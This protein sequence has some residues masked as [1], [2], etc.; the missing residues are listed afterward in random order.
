M[1]SALDVRK[2][3][4][5]RFDFNLTKRHSLELVIDRQKFEPTADYVRQ[6]DAAFIGFPGYA[7]SSAPKSE[8]VALRSS[9]TRNVVNELRYSQSGGKQLFG[10]VSVS[11]FAETGGFNLNIMSAGVTNPFL[12]Q[13]FGYEQLSEPIYELSDS[14]T[15]LGQGHT[16]N[17]GAQYKY[18]NAYDSQLSWLTPVISFAVDP[19]E[20]TAFSMFNGSNLPGSSPSQQNDARNLYATLVGRVSFYD[21]SEVLDENGQ[22]KENVPLTR[23]LAQKSYGSY[24]QDQWR[25]R[26]SLSLNFGIGWQPQEAFTV[27]TGNAGKLEDPEEIW[28]ISGP[29]NIFRPGVLSGQVPRVVLYQN[30]EK[31]YRDDLN[32]FAPS[33]GFVW[34]PGF[35]GPLAGFF[36]QS[37]RS[38]VRA[39]FSRSF[40]R[41]GS[42]QQSTPILNTPGAFLDASRSTGFGNFVIGTNLR[43]P[44]NPNLAP[45][46]FTGPAN[47][48][49][50]LNSG[51]GAAVTVDPN[52]QTGYVDSFS[53]GYQ[54]QIG[55]D[56][57]L[58][59]RYVGT[60][61]HRIRRTKNLNEINVIENGFADEFKMAQAN[62]YANLAA[63]RGASF[64][65]FGPGT[66]TSALPI[67]LAYFNSASN[68][69]PADP[70]RYAPANFTNGQ[71]V[72]LLSVNAPNPIGFVSNAAF[73]NNAV[74]RA[75]AASNGLPVN[76]F[77]VNPS[78]NR[79]NIL[80][81]DA[82]TWYD[83]GVIELR[84][85]L[86]DGLRIEASYVFSKALS[87]AFASNENQQSDY[88]LRPG[89]LDLARNVQV[90]D[91]RHAF[92]LNATYDLPAGRGKALFSDA[93]RLTNAF[94]GG[95][96]IVPVV[97]WQS[98]SPFSLGNVQ[99]AGMTAKELQNEIRVRKGPSVVTY[100]PD[101]II[102]NTQRAFNVSAVSP[103]GYGTTFGGPPQGRFIAPP[104]YG[105]CVQRFTGECGFTNLILHGPSFFMIDASV[106]KK[107]RI[108][109]KRDVEFRMTAFDVLNHPPFRV[110]GW[111][112]DVIGIG[113]GGATFGQL[114]PGSAYQDLQGTNNPGG[115][116]IDLMLRFNF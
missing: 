82:S 92:K 37:G 110:G 87:N 66:G 11:D 102:L 112:S 64:A 36:G 95:W 65:Y 115:R 22:F 68:Y 50:V 57:V 84:R 72:N 55:Q 70:A 6:L 86:S 114:G 23:T 54:R 9:L 29:G 27:K 88:T 69:D 99:L 63:G 38:V 93:R 74:R 59:V 62:L 56:T 31:A 109:E 32:N 76:F 41:E 44:N 48:P 100:L 90:F 43:D 13:N 35:K 58:E 8:S 2:F 80:S 3:L 94:V 98:G 53:V 52:I 101:D 67:M 104:G 4:T 61:G 26:Q 107:F 30:G 83:S 18:I 17:F 97:R 111:D 28:G 10:T 40:I 108:D 91:I 33:F 12:L 19:S 96:S 75:N 105:N 15:W 16:V 106:A 89:G 7:F 78:V 25:L 79:A 73:E 21:S 113:V 24:I 77:R 51:S 116:I 81:D 42:I 5:L 47:F 60:R 46:Q 49:L 45:Q 14:V 85:R 39:G 34:S 103:T 20:G 71:L 1:N